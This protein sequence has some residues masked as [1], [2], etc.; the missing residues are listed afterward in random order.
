MKKRL[1]AL[2]CGI[3]VTVSAAAILAP[4]MTNVI[5]TTVRR[6]V[7]DAHQGT[8]EDS[9]QSPHEGAYQEPDEEPD[10]A[11][12]GHHAGCDRKESGGG[13]EDCGR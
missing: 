1:L 13:E 12:T 2:L 8:H 10:S 11:P 5:S 6:S 4:K 7:Q 3:T 9:Y